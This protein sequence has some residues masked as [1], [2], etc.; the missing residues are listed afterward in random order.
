MNRR[1]FLGSL[2]ALSA[3]MALD[4]D[5]ALWVP[6]RTTYFDLAGPRHDTLDTWLEIEFADASVGHYR[7]TSDPRLLTGRVVGDFITRR[8]AAVA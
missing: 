5:R 7:I 3:G 1:H 4:T 2:A 6:G 8:A